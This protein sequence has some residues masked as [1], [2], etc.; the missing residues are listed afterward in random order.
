MSIESWNSL[1]H[2]FDE[3]VLEISNHDLNGVI[4]EQIKRLAKNGDTAADLGCGPGSLLPHLAK[5]FDT[6]YA[7]DYAD[8]L[9][10]TAKERNGERNVKY[11]CHDLTST[12][13]LPFTAD[14]TFSVNA[15]ITADHASRKAIAQSLWHTTRKNGFNVVVVPSMESTLHVYQTLVRINDHQERSR[16]QAVRDM[17][18]LHKKEVL[19]PVDGIV[20][21]GGV[22]TKCFTREEIVIFLSEIGFIVE[23]VS[24]VEY[25]W[26]EEIDDSPRWLEGPYPWDWLIVRHKS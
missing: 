11:F 20:S 22:P 23:E 3:N 9:L 2:N 19:S 24:K 18:R 12:K 17:D 1:A 16:G 15:L 5:K 13:P 4:N 26:S 6:V 8:E 21:I 10:R 25:P 14:V 7:V